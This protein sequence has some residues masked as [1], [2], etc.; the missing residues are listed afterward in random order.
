MGENNPSVHVK[1]WGVM[2]E[3]L[4]RFRPPEIT[5]ENQGKERRYK[6]SEKV[7]DVFSRLVF[8]SSRIVHHYRFFE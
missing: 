8:S 2:L 1:R 7:G 3:Y 4:E 5:I 6:Y